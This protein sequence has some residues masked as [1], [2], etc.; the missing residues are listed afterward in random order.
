M[1]SRN[2]HYSDDGAIS[3]VETEVGDPGPGE[4]Q[5]RGG[6][7]GICAWDI[8][9]C[10]LGKKIRLFAPPGHEGIGYVHKTGPGVA[11]LREGDRVFSGGFQNYANHPAIHVHK[12]PDSP[13]PDEH[14]LVEPV[15]CVVTGMDTARL[16]AGDRVALVGCGFMGL[17]FA[18][19]LARSPLARLLALDIETSRLELARGFGIADTR[20]L[21]AAPADAAALLRELKGDEGFDVVIDTTGTQGGLDTAAALVATGG[22]INLFGWLKGDRANF[23]PSLWHLNG[24]TIVNS[25][26]SA[27]VRDPLPAAMR[28]ISTGLVKLAPLVSHIVSMD[29]Y[30]GL[31]KKILAGDKTYI[32]G[33][34]RTAPQTV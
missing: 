13:L 4:V 20:A 21:P 25:S 24:C 28:L 1:K 23:D 9:T 16:R 12:L 19:L 11:G 26:P 31:M 8:A 27:R 32:K 10:K 15:A 33:V 34:V 30:A 29:D 5:V 22:Q 6:A 7:C 17:L 14:W 18:Q 3:V 2:I